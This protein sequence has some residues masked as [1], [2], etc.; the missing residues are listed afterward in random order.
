[1]APTIAVVGLGEV[2]RPLAELI[3][4]AGGDVL[5]I[6]VEP[7]TLPEPGALDV[8][9]VCF[10]FEIP[11]FVGEVARYAT[12]LEP[13]LTVVNST[14]AVGTTRAIHEQTGVRIAHSPV[15]GKHA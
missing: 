1:M 15:R 10:P 14:V 11:D 9:H 3:E 8:M 13:R 2:G 6:D 12:R 5:R 7:L 4:R